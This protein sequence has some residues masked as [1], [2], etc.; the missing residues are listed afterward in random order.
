MTHNSLKIH[1]C[2]HAN[3]IFSEVGCY[4]THTWSWAPFGC[5]RGLANVK[6][7]PICR[8]LRSVAWTIFIQYVFE[9]WLVVIK[10]WMKTATQ[11]AVAP[12]LIRA[13]TRDFIHSVGCMKLK[14]E[15]KVGS[16]EIKVKTMFFESFHADLHRIFKKRFRI[17][18][19]FARSTFLNYI[20]C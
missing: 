1:H 16:L 17:A 7:I 5:G 4:G 9:Q 2:R 14:C 8:N 6:G 10:Q 12:L 15:N 19:S 3:N 18:F 11:V 13:A 20:T